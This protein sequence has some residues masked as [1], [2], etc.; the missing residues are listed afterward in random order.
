M[1]VVKRLKAQNYSRTSQFGLETRRSRNG[2][3]GCNVIERMLEA[4]EKAAYYHGGQ[5]F[6]AGARLNP[7]TPLRVWPNLPEGWRAAIKEAYTDG[8]TN[9]A[10]MQSLPDGSPA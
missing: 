6:Y 1:G 8:W 5:D 7:E 3:K 10:L 4:K 2:Q 9:E